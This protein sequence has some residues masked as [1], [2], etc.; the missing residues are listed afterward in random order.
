[1]KI[2]FQWEKPLCHN[3]IIFR[4][5]GQNILNTVDIVVKPMLITILAD[6]TYPN[7]QAFKDDRVTGIRGVILFTRKNYILL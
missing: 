5:H 7:V 2:P 3:F 6:V 1:M 4:L